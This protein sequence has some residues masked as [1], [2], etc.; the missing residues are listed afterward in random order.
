MNVASVTFAITNTCEHT[1]VKTENS[2]G[3]CRYKT[4]KR[5]SRDFQRKNASNTIVGI[6]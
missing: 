3:I 2:C 4:F 6:S 1:A 5:V